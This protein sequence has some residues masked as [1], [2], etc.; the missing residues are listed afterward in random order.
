MQ[1]KHILTA[2]RQAPSLGTCTS[3]G[4]WVLLII[5][6]CIASDPSLLDCLSSLRYLD[7]GAPIAHGP[8]Q[9][10]KCIGG[11]SA[12]GPVVVKACLDCG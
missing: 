1:T 2:G 11:R 6:D 9:R 4:W 7:G 10:S 12:L 3:A 8:R 5:G